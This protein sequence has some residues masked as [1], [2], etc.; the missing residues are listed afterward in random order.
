L[1]PAPVTVQYLGFP[2]TLNVPGIDYV[3][4]D[5][6]VTPPEH[7]AHCFL[8][9][10]AF[11]PSTYMVNDHRQSQLHQ[12]QGDFSVQNARNRSLPHHQEIPV[13]ANFNHLQKLGPRTFDLWTQIMS[14]PALRDS[15]LWMLKFPGEAEPH[16]KREMHNKGVAEDR[17]LLT[18]KFA[19]AEHL[20]VK[21]AASI[22]L[23]TLEY[24]AHVSGL[25]ALWVGLPLLTLAGSNMARRCGASFLRT[26]KI[27]ELLARTEE[28][29]VAIGQRLASAGMHKGS[30]LRELR[31]RV[32]KQRL[33][34]ELFDTFRWVKHLER[35]LGVMWEVAAASEGQGPMNIA[36]SGYQGWAAQAHS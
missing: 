26:S 13:L 23:D 12:I 6:I 21:R 2:Y 24:N 33:E 25:D 10:V 32:E 30:K 35:L 29:Y 20:S 34:G 3:L 28:E 9:K 17:L 18:D 15:K 11:M 7:H 19:S 14:H 1:R 8:E 16:L 31:E 5:R 22:L 36:L 4:T 27:P